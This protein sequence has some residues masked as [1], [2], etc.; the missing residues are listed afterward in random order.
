MPVK[1][2]PI[3]PSIAERK[4]KAIETELKKAQESIEK[5]LEISKQK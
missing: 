5:A 1:N 3:P 4:L 2:V